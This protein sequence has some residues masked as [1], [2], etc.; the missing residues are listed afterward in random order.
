MSE[1]IRELLA[2]DSEQALQFFT[3]SLEEKELPNGIIDE[4]RDYIASV[5]AHYAL[6]PRYTHTD[7][8]LRSLSDVFDHFVLKGLFSK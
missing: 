4:E 5:L 3:N 1:L 6:T 8:S 2:V 7:T